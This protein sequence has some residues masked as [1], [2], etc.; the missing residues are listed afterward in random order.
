MSGTLRA[1]LGAYSSQFS[2]TRRWHRRQPTPD[3]VADSTP[4]QRRSSFPHAGQG[5]TSVW[6]FSGKYLTS[7]ACMPLGALL[8]FM[9]AS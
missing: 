5:R 2:V 3:V 6:A 1:G 8:A 9:S 4:N 7:T